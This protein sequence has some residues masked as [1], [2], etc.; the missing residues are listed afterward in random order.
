MILMRNVSVGFDNYLKAKQMIIDKIN[1][2]GVVTFEYTNTRNVDSP[3]LSNFRLIA[4]KGA[5]GKFDATFNGSLTIFDKL[6]MGV[7]KRIRDFQFSGQ[8]DLLLADMGDA[9]N[10]VL[11]FS[12]RYERLMEDAM[13]PDG[14]M[15]MDTKGDIAIGQAKLTIPVK[16]GFKIPISVT[17]ANRTELIKEKEVRG[18]IGF[19]FD[20]DALFAR[21]KL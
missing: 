9:G 18:N 6:P 1:Q 2:G 15:V 5:G 13:T 8:G 10:I 16:G 3:N 7:T 4:E 14:M 21:F 17:F 19:T 20:L 11:S 12:G